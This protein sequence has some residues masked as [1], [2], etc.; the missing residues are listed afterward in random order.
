MAE[1]K[2][3]KGIRAAVTVSAIILVGVV[4]WRVAFHIPAPAYR[5]GTNQE[6]TS[7]AGTHEHTFVPADL[8]TAKKDNSSNEQPKAT[9]N[10][11]E[12]EQS[13]SPEKPKLTLQQVVQSARGWGPAFQNWYGQDAPD[14]VLADLDGKEY[15][16][17]DYKGRNVM[18]VFWATWCRP[19]L[20]EIPHLIEL[21]KSIS[22]DKLAILAITNEPQIVVGNFLGNDKLNYTILIAN[23][24]L[25]APYSYVRGIP[26]SFYIDTEGKIKFG[27]TGLLKFDAMKAIIEAEE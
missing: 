1:Q 20:M 27:T 17:S 6:Y 4:I 9:L 16:L 14:F 24:Q 19:C 15:G 26:S 25:L 2:N 3:K 10:N 12:D 18:L 23:T 5:S 11:I 7:T 13:V 22:E 8:K 21:R